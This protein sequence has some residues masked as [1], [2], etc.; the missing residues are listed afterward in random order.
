MRRSREDKDCWLISTQ[1]APSAGPADGDA[2]DA[3]GGLADPDRHAL[4]VLAAGADAGIKRKI[5]ADHAHTGERVGAVANQHRALDR[6]TDLAVLDP[7]GLGAL[8]HEF[9]RRDV[10]LPAAKTHRV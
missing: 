8:E 1:K 3:Q 2:V 10:D 6:G 5:G 9:S 4:A 7:V